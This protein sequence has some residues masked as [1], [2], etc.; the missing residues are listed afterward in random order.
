MVL[1]Q[2]LIKDSEKENLKKISKRLGFTLSGFVRV[3]A[4]KKMREENIILNKS[5]VEE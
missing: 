4:L 1:L 2:I 5:G 3:A